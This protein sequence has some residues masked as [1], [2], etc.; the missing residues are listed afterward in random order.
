VAQIV[1]ADFRDFLYWTTVHRILLL[2]IS[3][4]RCGE[5]KTRTQCPIFS[6]C[7]SNALG[8][9]YA[10]D[11]YDI[12]YD[13]ALTFLSPTGKLS[14]RPFAAFGALDEHGVILRNEAN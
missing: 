7:R 10:Y 14:I 5:L 2:L 11:A 8:T 12:A 13:I 9:A 6:Q 3:S 4:I 1:A